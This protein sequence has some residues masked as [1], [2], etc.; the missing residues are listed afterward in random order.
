M[1]APPFSTPIHQTSACPFPQRRVTPTSC[2][3]LKTA[4][5]YPY[6]AIFVKR[7][8]RIVAMDESPPI[9]YFHG[10]ANQDALQ[11]RRNPENVLLS[12]HFDK[13]KPINS[14]KCPQCNSML[15]CKSLPDCLAF[16]RDA[17]FSPTPRTLCTAI[18]KVFL[19]T[20]PDLAS[21]AVR[22]HLPKSIATSKGHLDQQ[23]Q[24]IQ[25]T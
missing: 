5:S 2:P 19:T 11:G 13:V 12:L 7:H 6:V 18:N 4:A 14:R 21:A 23:R 24:G 20:F 9:S 1:M 25:S 16:L 17:L 10:P 8:L 22:K 3:V 15:A